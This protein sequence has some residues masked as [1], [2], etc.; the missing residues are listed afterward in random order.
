MA[1]NEMPHKRPHTTYMCM[2]QAAA[3]AAATPAVETATKTLG[4]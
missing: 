3:A 2:P 4:N 1:V